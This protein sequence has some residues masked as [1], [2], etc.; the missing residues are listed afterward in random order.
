MR[1][2]KYAPD[3]HKFMIQKLFLGAFLH[4]IFYG[5]SIS[6]IMNRH[7]CAHTQTQKKMSDQLVIHTYPFYTFKAGK[8]RDINPLDV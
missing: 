2:M 8:V 4:K 5:L 7:G 3:L 1:K 6:C